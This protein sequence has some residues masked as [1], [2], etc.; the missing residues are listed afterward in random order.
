M[1]AQEMESILTQVERLS[2]QER[3]QLVKRITEMAGMTDK[4]ATPQS[5][6]RA[7]AYQSIAAYAARHA[8]SDADLDAALD[9][10]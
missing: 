4:A 9:L 8:G 7:V 2:P 10:A 5:S 6:E 3:L 1:S